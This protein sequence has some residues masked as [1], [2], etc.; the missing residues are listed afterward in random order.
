MTI[1][2]G[3]PEFP[4]PNGRVELTIMITVLYCRNGSVTGL[5]QLPAIV[6]LMP[7][8]IV[9]MTVQLYGIICWNDNYIILE[10]RFT[11]DFLFP[12]KS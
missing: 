12:K 6:V 3:V 10:K 11:Q 5:K 9:I 2:P 4:F 1:L 8:I 7:V